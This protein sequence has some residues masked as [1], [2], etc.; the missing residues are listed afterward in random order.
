MLGFVCFMCP[1]PFSVSRSSKLVFSDM[2][3]DAG[4]FNALNGLGGGGQVDN[5]TGANANA[6]LYSTFAVSAFFAGYVSKV[7]SQPLT[8]T[9]S[10]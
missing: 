5:T 4:L 6:A 9:S 2:F 7:V 10:V 8:Y 3:C 1:G